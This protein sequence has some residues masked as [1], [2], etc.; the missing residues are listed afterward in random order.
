MTTYLDIIPTDI[1]T[2]IL[3]KL[4]INDI[5]ILYNVYSKIINN[6]TFWYNKI[7]YSFPLLNIKLLSNYSYTFK[8]LPINH[9]IYQYNLLTAS[10]AKTIK[11]LHYA[12]G[13]IEYY[14]KDKF[15]GIMKDFNSGKIQEIDLEVIKWRFLLLYINNVSVMLFDEI[16]ELGLILKDFPLKSNFDRLS[17]EVKMRQDLRYAVT[18]HGPFDVVI[19]VSYEV[20]L[21]DVFNILFHVYFN[22]G[23]DISYQF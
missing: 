21:M 1:I 7:K 5:G 19:G 16:P 18:V 2:L 22:G 3:L 15:M 12:L 17:I 4:S 13:E 9:I 23:E 20:K 10:Y 11:E 14:D 8:D 6:N